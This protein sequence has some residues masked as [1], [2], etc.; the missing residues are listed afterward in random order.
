MQSYATNARSSVSFEFGEAY[1][2]A[3]IPTRHS[4]VDVGANRGQWAELALRFFPH[5][6][7]L[8]IEPDKDASQVA[9]RA[10]PEHATIIDGKMIG[11]DAQSTFVPGDQ[12]TGG[13]HLNSLPK[14]K[15]VFEVI[16]LDDLVGEYLKKDVDYIKIDTDGFDLDVL[17]SGQYVFSNHRPMFQIELGRFATINSISHTQLLRWGEKLDYL[18]FIILP[19]GIRRVTS[20]FELG[21]V[22]TSFNVFGCPREMYQ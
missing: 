19:R 1:L 17:A 5:A 7:Y 16:T 18:L 4:I 9:K 15:Q 11:T 22:R 8:G 6:E 13:K 14:G 2:L 12:L 20:P 3:S 21:N 10:L